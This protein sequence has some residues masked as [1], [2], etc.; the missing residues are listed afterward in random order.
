MANVLIVTG[1]KPLMLAAGVALQ[2]RIL[3]RGQHKQVHLV[4][5][6]WENYIETVMSSPI[7]KI[8][9]LDNETPN[10]IGLKGLE[11]THWVHFTV[12]VKHRD[13]EAGQTVSLYFLANDRVCLRYPDLNPGRSKILRLAGT[14]WPVERYY[15]LEY[16][17]MTTMEAALQME[18]DL[19]TIP[20]FKT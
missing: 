15:R 13:P 11:N 20:D 1:M 5:N 17:G 9:F 7:T 18:K 8:I 6:G 12:N 4:R 10:T 3:K 14:K 2:E 19:Q 16:Y